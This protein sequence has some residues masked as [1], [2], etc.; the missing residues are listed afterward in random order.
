MSFRR[1]KEISIAPAGIIKNLFIYR[2]ILFQMVLREIKGRFAG[3]IG[4]MFWSVA[5]PLLLLAVYLFVFIYI[6]KLKVGSSGGAGTSAIY[7]MAGLFPWLI[8]SEGLSRGT[9]SLIENANLI[10]KTSF[11]VE[12]LTSKA[13]IAPFIGHGIAILLLALYKTIFSGSPVIIPVLLLLIII[14]VLFTLGIAFLTA[15]ATVFFRDVMQLIQVITSFWIYLT[16]IFY[17]TNMLPEWARIGMYF[18]PLYPLI[19]TYQSLFVKGTIE[20]FNML[21]LSLMWSIFFFTIGAYIFNKLKYE[22]ADWL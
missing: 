19:A 14:Q 18:N 13:V 5:H 8:I 7:I 15:A 6:F 20:G 16:P 11:P 22:F 12:I 3:T 1:L 10:Q 17:P 9:S 21:L 2:H 4:G